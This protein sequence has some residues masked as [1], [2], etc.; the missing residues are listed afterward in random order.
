MVSNSSTCLGQAVETA[1]RD[2]H[3]LAIRNLRVEASSDRIVLSGVVDSFYQKQIAQE[4][5]RQLDGNT[6]VQN[7]IEVTV[8]D[9]R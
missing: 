1:I 9:C 5:V 7:D 8:S 4:L 6:R 3:L 2:S